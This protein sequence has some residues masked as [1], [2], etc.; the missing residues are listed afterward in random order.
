MVTVERKGFDDRDNDRDKPLENSDLKEI[1]KQGNDRD[2]RVKHAGIM[3]KHYSTISFVIMAEGNCV[4]RNGTNRK[5]CK[6][7]LRNTPR[8]LNM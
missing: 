8:P 5:R 2:D 7:L 1:G 6:W 3:R 4:I